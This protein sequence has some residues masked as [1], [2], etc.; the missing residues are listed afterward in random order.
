MA[1]LHQTHLASASFAS[2]AASIAWWAVGDKRREKHH[3]G[4]SSPLGV[5]RLEGILA[6]TV[7]RLV[8]TATE[9]LLRDSPAN[10]RET[11]GT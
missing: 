2:P 8:P 10:W 11:S 7:L 5:G 3:R 4:S 1:Q 6:D 9:H